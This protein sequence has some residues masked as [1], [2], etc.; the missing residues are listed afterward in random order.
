MPDKDEVPGSS[1]GRPTTVL[2]AQSAAAP[3]PVAPTACLGRV[4]AAHLRAV[5]P[6]ALPE[7]ATQRPSHGRPHTGDHVPDD[8]RAAMPQ[9]GEPR[10]VPG[11]L[12]TSGPCATGSSGRGP[13][14]DHSQADASVGPARP[15]PASSVRL[16]LGQTT[17][18]SWTPCGATTPTPAV[19]AVWLLAAS[20]RLTNS[21]GSDTADVERPDSGRRMP[22]CPDAQLDTGHRTPTPD[23]GHPDAGRRSRGHRTRGHWMRGHWTPDTGH[24]M[25]L[26]TGQAD[27]AG[28]APDILGHHA[29]R[30]PAGTPNRVPAD[31]AC[32][33]RRPMQ[34][35]R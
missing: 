2:P 23:S 16:R 27:K 30:V 9:V 28:P 21:P 19:L 4:G 11:S 18:R 34:A 17:S 24:R 12:P 5:A 35:R 8:P 33:A 15:A 31:G 7:Q 29:E 22:R 1:P 14:D 3:R 10:R 25:L 6:K 26:R 32:G 20:A 13:P